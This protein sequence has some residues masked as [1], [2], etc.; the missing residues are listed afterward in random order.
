MKYI[1]KSIERKGYKHQC[2]HLFFDE[3]IGN[4]IPL[5]Y[6]KETNYPSDVSTI[7]SKKPFILL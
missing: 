1:E 4:Y 6:N 7:L 2:Y 5:G 3:K